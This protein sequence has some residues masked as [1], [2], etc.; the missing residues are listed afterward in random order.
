MDSMADSFCFTTYTSPLCRYRDIQVTGARFL[1][2]EDEIYDDILVECFHIREPSYKKPKEHPHLKSQALMNGLCY[3]AEDVKASSRFVMICCYEYLEDGSIRLM[4]NVDDE[5]PSIIISE[6]VKEV[7]N[8]IPGRHNEYGDT[9][10]DDPDAEEWDSGDYN[11]FGKAPKVIIT[12][13]AYVIVKQACPSLQPHVLL[14]LKQYCDKEYGVDGEFVLTRPSTTERI[15]DYGPLNATQKKFADWVALW[16]ETTE[17]LIIRGKSQSRAGNGYSQTLVTLSNTLFP[18]NE[19][20]P[21][22]DPFDDPEENKQE[23]TAIINNI[24]R[25]IF[26]PICE[27]LHPRDIAS[28]LGTL[29]V[30]LQAPLTSWVGTMKLTTGSRSGKT[31]DTLE[32]IWRL[33]SHGLPIDALVVTA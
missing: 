23:D 5:E 2:S 10:N 26:L 31:L 18:I 4:D 6:N 15:I 9:E 14:R 3:T 12:Q 17:M 8:V 20:K 16:K 32:M 29:G 13:R 7:F 27:M 25:D 1:S 28:I 22:F 19:I 21:S 33:E 11:V 24:P 30:Y